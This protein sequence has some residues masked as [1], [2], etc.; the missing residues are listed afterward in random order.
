MFKKCWGFQYLGLCVKFWKIL[1]FGKKRVSNVWAW[2][3]QDGLFLSSYLDVLSSND[4]TGDGSVNFKI[5]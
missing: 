4:N 2:R 1:K 3:N 5:D